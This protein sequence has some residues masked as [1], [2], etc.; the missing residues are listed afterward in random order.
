MSEVL[1]FRLSLQYVKPK[2]LE[3]MRTLKLT[4]EEIEII[5]SALVLAGDTI[6]KTI[7]NGKPFLKTDTITDMMQTNYDIENLRTSI[8]NSEKDV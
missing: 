6:T 5:N 2:E 7:V 3:I 8:E 1:L 4:H